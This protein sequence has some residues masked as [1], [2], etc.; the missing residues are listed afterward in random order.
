MM[1]KTFSIFRWLVLSALLIVSFAGFSQT[2]TYE[3]VKYTI[4]DATAK[5]VWIATQST[6]S[7]TVVIPEN[8][9]Y[10][11]ETYTV[12]GSND[13]A[14]NDCSELVS[15]TF[16][17]TI[18]ALNNIWNMSNKCSKLKEITVLGGDIYG[19]CSNLSALE[20]LTIGENVTGL[21][22]YLKSTGTRF[23][24][25]GKDKF[26]TIHYYPKH[27]ETGECL[28]MPGNSFDNT[29][30]RP[31]SLNTNNS[32]ANIYI[33]EGV[34]Y[35]GNYCFYIPAVPNKSIHRLYLP[36][37]LTEIGEGAFYANIDT[38]YCSAA[39]PPKI[40]IKETENPD[41]ATSP[42]CDVL[43]LSSFKKKSVFVLKVPCGSEE[44]YK[45]DPQWSQ[46]DINMIIPYISEQIV[47]TVCEGATTYTDKY[48]NV[49]TITQD[50][51]TFKYEHDI[52]QSEGE[53]KCK[54]EVVLTL[55]F[56]H[57][58]ETTI[59]K[60]LCAGEKYYEEGGIKYEAGKITKKGVYKTYYGCDSTVY[61]NVV[62]QAPVYEKS[63]KNV[64][65][66]ESNFSSNDG[67]EN[68]ASS[69][70]KNKNQWY[71]GDPNKYGTNKLFITNGETSSSKYN[72][73]VYYKE[74]PES[75][76]VSAY[77]VVNISTANVTDSLDIDLSLIANGKDATDGG[78]L[79][80]LVLPSSTSITDA[81]YN[82]E[83]STNVVQYNNKYYI[84][85]YG[86]NA[87]SVKQRIKN[88]LSSA[89][90]IKIVLL[91]NNGTG[92]Q[93]SEANAVIN[94]VKLFSVGLE[95]QY[96]CKGESVDI[97]GQQI[98][99]NGV[100]AWKTDSK[101]EDGCP[102]YKQVNVKILEIEEKEAETATI[103]S[104]GSYVWD[105]DGKTYNSAGTYTYIESKSDNSGC[106]KYTL[107]LIVNPADNENLEV[108]FCEEAKDGSGDYHTTY[109]G[110]DVNLGS[111]SVG[112]TENVGPFNLKNTTNCYVNVKYKVIILPNED[113]P[114]NE[115]ICY[116][117]I[118]TEGYTYTDDYTAEGVTTTIDGEEKKT[119][120]IPQS[121]LQEAADTTYTK[122]LT[123][124]YTKGT[125][126]CTRTVKLN[127]NVGPAPTTVEGV[128]CYGEKFSKEI[129]FSDGH[130]E[131]L[132]FTNV[133]SDLNDTK[134]WDNTITNGEDSKNCAYTV[135]YKIT[136]H[137][138]PENEERP[139]TLC[140]NEEK[141]E[142]SFNDKSG[143]TRTVS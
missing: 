72:T 31:F 44:K 34:E 26:V 43:S 39:T 95:D 119:Y 36:S 23:T 27:I 113:K 135:T 108:V 139:A 45:T 22:Q 5:K 13:N 11:G 138:K 132:E 46:L 33:H 25:G 12:T 3:G 86:T 76:K 69:P 124:T 48:G 81:M 129:E 120:T 71:R 37:T 94:S 123:I 98:T 117:D 126:T 78:W 47:D 140:W 1:T 91:W 80:V 58:K 82:K 137:P 52:E 28:K 131:T 105:K 32:L 20:V 142:A 57:P 92:K 55:Y 2:F 109:N 59:V 107:N 29:V 106:I 121:A 19:L 64:I 111:L 84:N 65:L 134:T 89:G 102:I 42:K 93:N 7:G 68:L 40:T 41:A 118:P 128:V 77:K 114:I 21:H 143:A 85:G 50:G 38:V 122:D 63:E 60:T 30:S 16:P 116:N 67:W 99:T 97:N 17:S 51:Q 101:T 112:T 103:C 127:I 87:I 130:K 141:Y 6:L 100:Y 104:G 115:I 96:L 24:I 18:E 8:V 83:Y 125:T 61:Y 56:G 49:H 73:G 66:Y 133:T 35:I 79:K 90:N 53:D 75:R 15:I 136:V 14:L 70:A 110:Q 74:K 54:G 4:K 62:E 10:N 9:E 88:P